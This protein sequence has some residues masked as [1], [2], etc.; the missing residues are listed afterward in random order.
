MPRIGAELALPRRVAEHDHA[1]RAR[2][3]LL[4][5]E[6]AAEERLHAE[7]REVIGRHVAAG[8]PR[9]ARRSPSTVAVDG[10]SADS[11]ANDWLCRLSSTKLRVVVE[12]VVV[13]VGASQTRTMR[14]GSGKGSGLNSTA[15][16]QAEH[17]GVG[18]DAQGQHADR[19]Q[20]ERRHRGPAPPGRSGCR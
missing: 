14:S 9:S 5:P 2:L 12:L 15:V 18:A 7:H 20:R 17:R 13:A 11:A 4:R 16:H 10:D 19:H 3:V 1:R 6:G 8:Q